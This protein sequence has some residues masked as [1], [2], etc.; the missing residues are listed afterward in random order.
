MSYSSGGAMITSI[1]ITYLWL[2]HPVS[3][4]L[5]GVLACM[6]VCALHSCVSFVH[7]TVN[8]TQEKKPLQSFWSFWYAVPLSSTLEVLPFALLSTIA[9][10]G[11][12]QYIL[13][14][15][16]S[17]LCSLSPCTYTNKSSRAVPT[18]QGIN[19]INKI[20]YRIPLL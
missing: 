4:L 17:T 19:I 18:N 13:Q 20:C 8:V 14:K 7:N 3:A 2:W 10:A 6:L 11:V 15:S 9:N 1:T 16:E 12:H 5:C